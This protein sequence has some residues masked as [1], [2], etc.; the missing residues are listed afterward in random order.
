[1]LVRY[2]PTG[3]VIRYTIW[4][5]WKS[6]KNKD[7]NTFISLLELDCPNILIITW[8]SWLPK[9]WTTSKTKYCKDR[10]SMQWN[11]DQVP[12]EDETNTREFSPF[13]SYYS[14]QDTTARWTYIM[15]LCT[16]SKANQA[17]VYCCC[18]ADVNDTPADEL[19]FAHSRPLWA[20]FRGGLHNAYW[21]LTSFSRSTFPILST[22]RKQAYGHS[23]QHIR[24]G[25]IWI[26]PYSGASTNQSKS[27]TEE[28]MQ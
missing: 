26:S 10:C 12:T 8:T 21:I 1:M 25:F 13:L 24:N 23:Q 22:T 9:T 18:R 16:F 6:N 17:W 5:K 7:L 4:G 2:V 28:E 19:L 20:E 27:D 3:T 11:N 15:M 14:E